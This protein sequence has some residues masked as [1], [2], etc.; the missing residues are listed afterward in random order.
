MFDSADEFWHI[1]VFDEPS[2]VSTFLNHVRL[3][4]DQLVNLTF[5]PLSPTVQRIMVTCRL[6]AEQRE[7][8][9]QWI[10]VERIINPPAVS[11]ATG[12]GH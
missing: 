11:V 10:A 2:Q 5:T 8:R 12:G 4:P 9:V 7:L 1:E 6:T 3:R